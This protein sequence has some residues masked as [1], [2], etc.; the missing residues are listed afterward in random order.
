MRTGEDEICVSHLHENKSS[1][2]RPN[3]A[4]P[5]KTGSSPV[6]PA[7]QIS[8]STMT[9][10]FTT[11]I[12]LDDRGRGVDCWD[13]GQGCRSRPGQNRIWVEPGGDPLSASQPHF[14]SDLWCD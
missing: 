12:E 6:V 2:T 1:A 7:I 5:C 9:A 4:G 13:E 11:Q 8:T 3:E 14:G 10:F